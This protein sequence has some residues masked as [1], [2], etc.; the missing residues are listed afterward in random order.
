MK[1]NHF[2]TGAGFTST[3]PMQIMVFSSEIKLHLLEDNH[4]LMSLKWFRMNAK[5]E[6]PIQHTWTCIYSYL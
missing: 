3:L 2:K 4:I 5:K 6:N 1:T